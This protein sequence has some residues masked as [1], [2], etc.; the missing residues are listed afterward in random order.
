MGGHYYSHIKSFENNSWS[1][2]NDTHVH[3]ISYE[4]IENTYGVENPKFN[5]GSSAYMLSY[6]KV[7]VQDG[8]QIYNAPRDPPEYIAELVEKERKRAIENEEKWKK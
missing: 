7:K 1:T 6:R 3:S 4:T 2:Y 5:C 8:K